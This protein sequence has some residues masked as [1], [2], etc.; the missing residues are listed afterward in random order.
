MNDKVVKHRTKPKLQLV[1]ITYECR[2]ES[3]KV[4]PSGYS[5]QEQ[6]CEMC[7]SHGKITV[8]VDRCCACGKS[9]H[10]ELDTW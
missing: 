10:F 8:T 4:I 7:G 2:G 6:D 5:A 9:H 1:E 3:F